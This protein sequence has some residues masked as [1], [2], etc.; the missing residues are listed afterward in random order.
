MVSHKPRPPAV[1]GNT[2]GKEGGK[3]RGEG[4]HRQNT[5]ETSA[6]GGRRSAGTNQRGEF[7]PETQP[8]PPGF[9]PRPR[10]AAGGGQAAAGL[11]GNADLRF[12]PCLGS[13]PAQGTGAFAGAALPEVG[14]DFSFVWF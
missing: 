4:N 1:G 11:G 5:V 10:E 12:A 14:G 2:E 6:E 8:A 7:H 3:G 9:C 13:P